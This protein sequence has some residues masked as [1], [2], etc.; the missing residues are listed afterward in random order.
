MFVFRGAENAGPE[1]T[2]PENAGTNVGWKMRD[3][4]MQE[5][6]EMRRNF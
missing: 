3:L 1:N 2:R 5:Y 6:L 4:K